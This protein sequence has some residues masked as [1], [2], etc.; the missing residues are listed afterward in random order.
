M[1]R[2][3]ALAQFIF[4]MTVDIFVNGSEKF[5]LPIVSESYDFFLLPGDRAKKEKKI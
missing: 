2:R 1:D 5:V 3:L 4:L